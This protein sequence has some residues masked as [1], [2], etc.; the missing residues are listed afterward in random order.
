ML[1][2]YFR[3]AENGTTVRREVLGGIITFLTMAYIIFVQPAER[4]QNKAHHRFSLLRIF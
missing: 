3:L 2:R 1:Q 4:I